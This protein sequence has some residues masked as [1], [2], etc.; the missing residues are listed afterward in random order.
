MPPVRPRDAASLVIHRKRDTHHEVLMGRRGKQ[1]R[2]KPGVYVF[3]GGGL[4]RSDYL[5]VPVRHLAEDVPP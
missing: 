2:F 4:E 1:A 3:P 5:A